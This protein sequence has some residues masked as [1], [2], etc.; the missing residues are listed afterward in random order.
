[1]LY[2]LH[3]IGT[4]AKNMMAFKYYIL[5]FHRIISE[6]V[7]QKVISIKQVYVPARLCREI[8]SLS[9]VSVWGEFFFISIRAY[10]MMI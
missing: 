9:A 3:R 2:S 6:F 8:T 4:I 10:Q 5:I 1:M 7:L